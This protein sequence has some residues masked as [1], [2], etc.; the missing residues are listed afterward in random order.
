MLNYIKNYFKTLFNIRTVN[1]DKQII[2]LGKIIA[3]NNNRKGAIDSICDVEFS[4]YSQ[5]GEDG[6]ISWLIDLIKGIPKTFIEFGVETYHESNTRYL[7]QSRNWSGLVIDGS[8]QNIK[9]I[10]TQDISWRHSLHAVEQ[11]ITVDNINNIIKK[12]GYSGEIGLLSID[13]DGNDYWIWKKIDSVRPVIVVIEYNGVFGDLHQITINYNKY[14]RRNNGHFSNL[15]YGASLPALIAL[16]I[17]K[18][19]TFIGTVSSGCNAFFIRNDYR[20]YALNHISNCV[21]YPSLFRESRS[22][23]GNLTLTSGMDR[24][25]LIKHLEVID[26]QEN[27][28]KRLDE[29]SEIYSEEWQLNKPRKL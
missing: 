7:L 15:Y 18:G 9:K 22:I 5:W 8:E 12:S 14:F 23:T 28:I 17:E 27:V 2:L 6:I 20:E 4:V 11:F 3:E 25:D 24:L 1:F 19:Y 29:Y 21:A 16:G 26:M 13:I 10:K